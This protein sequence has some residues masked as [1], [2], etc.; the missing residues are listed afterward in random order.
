MNELNSAPSPYSVLEDSRILS[1]RPLFSV[2]VAVYA[3]EKYI[4]STLK[5][6]A[7]QDIDESKVEYIIVDDGSPD[8]AAQAAVKFAHKHRNVLVVQKP[9]GGVGQT[10]QLGLHLARGEW[11]T[12]VDPDDLLKSNYFSEAQ[13]FLDADTDKKI[14]IL[15]SRVLITDGTTGRFKD[16]HP[17]GAKFRR[18]NRVVSMLEEPSA[19]QMGATV[20]M[21]VDVLRKHKLTFDSRICPTFEDGNLVCRYLAHFENPLVGLLSTSHYYYRKRSDSS[22]L[23][24]SSWLKPERYTVVPRLGYLPALR[25]AQERLGYTPDWLAN[26]ILYDL[27]WYFKE[28]EKMGSVVAAISS[29][30]KKEFMEQAHEIFTYI[31]V[32]QVLRMPLNKPSWRLRESIIRGFN[33]DKAPARIFKWSTREDGTRNFS[34]LVAP[35]KH[36][37]VIYSG[38]EP[39]EVIPEGVTNRLYF[40][41]VLAVEYTLNLP[42]VPTAFFVDGIPCGPAKSLPAREKKGS[43]EYADN[44]TTIIRAGQHVDGKLAKILERLRVI[45][46]IQNRSVLAIAGIKGWE[47][48]QRL[49]SR[50]DIS[51]D[52]SIRQQVSTFTSSGKSQKYEQAWLILDHADRADDNGEHL[53]RYIL[54]H[55]S[56][57][58]AY[59]LLERDSKDWERLEA[60]GFKLL[61]YGSIE[62]MAA[63]QNAEV[64]ASSDA[65]EECIYPAPR[66]IFGNPDYKFV[67]LQHGIT[68]DDISRWLNGKKIDL[69]VAATEAEYRAFT[70]IESPYEYKS[71]QVCLAGFP[72][73]DNLYHLV[74]SRTIKNESVK[75]ILIMPTWR[76]DLKTELSECTSTAEEVAVIQDSSFYKNWWAVL[77]NATIQ[78]GIADGKIRVQ[79]MTHPSFGN[80]L[81]HLPQPH[82]IEFLSPSKVAFQPL[83]NEADLFL[84][85]YSSLAFDCAFMGTP[86]AYFQFDRD[87]VLSGAHT[88]RKGYFDYFE[89]GLGPVLLEEE[90][91]A[92]WVM[93]SVEGGCVMDDEYAQRRLQ[94]FKY[95][96]GNNSERVVQAIEK[97]VSGTVFNN[98]ADEQIRAEIKL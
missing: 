46:G 42:D 90:D 11:V 94:T 68:K 49:W 26:I 10:R 31:S 52:E 61:E 66:R 9:N 1:E 62:A 24:Q 67:F 20:F 5:S 21:Q 75:N 72:R 54:Q 96:D 71:S 51:S 83:M 88:Y 95:L 53:Y 63:A 92:Q 16:S 65:V 7:R 47:Y 41:E 14:A 13:R 6:F 36:D 74:C 4:T 84:T 8:N 32:E 19:I 98:V 23:V 97:L 25:Y 58:N 15:S 70:W 37:I 56:D 12:A 79:M 2:I 34:M 82:G 38:G 27:M 22:S 78:Q 85:D 76:Q 69:V 93:Q 59:F 64:V 39:I 18:G 73:Y 57:I 80:I 81:E 3:V 43:Q 28:D 48:L 86:V 89:Q 91:A 30:L 40:D 35:G 77:N 50:N 29:E 45:A 87:R 17:L 44:I 55:R 33:L 60:E